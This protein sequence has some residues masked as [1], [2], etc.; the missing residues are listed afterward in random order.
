VCVLAFGCICVA[1]ALVQSKKT[2][3]I[4]MCFG[5]ITLSLLCLY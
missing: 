5:A 1:W 3:R 4:W 2:F